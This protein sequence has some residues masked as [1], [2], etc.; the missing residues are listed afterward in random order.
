MSEHNLKIA[1]IG[2]GGW[3]KNHVRVLSDLGVLRA[4]CDSDENRALSVSKKHKIN[5][6]LNLRELFERT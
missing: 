1:V 6:Y 2:T 4:I 5:S 3:G